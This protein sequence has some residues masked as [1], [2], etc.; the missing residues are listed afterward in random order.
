[1]ATAADVPTIYDLVV[2]ST[3]YVFPNQIDENMPFRYQ[4]ARYGY[5]PT[6][7]ERSNTSGDYGDNQQDF[8]LTG[9]QRDWSLGEDQK[10]FK[11][12][13]DQKVRQFWLG[14]NINVSVPGQATIQSASAAL[15]FAAA[16][17][18]AGAN[19]AGGTTFASS[20][21]NLYEVSSAGAITD[22]GAHGCGGI[23]TSYATDGVNLYL[24]GAACTKTR[25]F[26]LVAHTFADFCATAMDDLVFMNNTLY[27]CHTG[28]FYVI[29]T[30]GNALPSFVWKDAT[31]TVLTGV[32][33]LN[34]FGGK[35][36]IMR[37]SG[38]TAGAELWQYDGVGVSKMA[39]YPANFSCSNICVQSGI[40]F[41]IGTEGKVGA[42]KR[43]ALWYY[44]NGTIGR[45]WANTTYTSSSN[46]GT[47]VTPFGNGLIFTDVVNG[48]LRF[49]DLQVGGI[50]SVASYTA[51]ASIWLATSNQFVLLTAASTAGRL[52]YSSTTATT[53]FI[54]TSIIDF[55][56]SLTKLFRGVIVD[57]T[58][59]TDGDG[60]SVD[61]AYQVDSVDGSYTTLQTGA[62]SG[63]EYDF[64]SV[65]TGRGISVKV[66]LNKGTSTLGPI[67]K[68]IYVRAAPTL[69]KF[70]TG[71]YVLDCT[72]RD[73]KTPIELRNGT[74]YAKSGQQL[75]TQFIS[76]VTAG[77]PVTFTD[78]LGTYTGIVELDNMD[79]F[80]IRPNEYWVRFVS[81]EV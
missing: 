72:G 51:A 49:Y 63:H 59:A 14:S 54:A 61:I 64:V 10:F 11:S 69:T 78:H 2:A 57:Y 17:S 58:A 33:H 24:S 62:T 25:K 29:D 21:T 70:R 48:V 7:V 30:G 55:D 44:A 47:D 80:E 16:A 42:G 1:M 12:A 5:T 73:G 32:M 34:A 71:E 9:S 67:L 15:T 28:T 53:G 46:T 3:G 27:G 23:V 13:D 77:T 76:D 60:G 31:G 37:S 4:R 52:L 22:R 81:R 35:V 79:I 50:S 40:V 18:G 36:M 65:I 8:W 19:P 41:L 6:F 38:S 45:A 39:E 68:R 43:T 56:S 66:T 74:E 75:L 20:S 26:A